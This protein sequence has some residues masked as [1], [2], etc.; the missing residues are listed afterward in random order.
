M[1]HIPTIEIRSDLFFIFT[2]Y[3]GANID[4]VRRIGE[5]FDPLQAPGWVD[6]IVMK[7]VQSI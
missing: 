1:D 2:H 7:V 6:R 4:H 3:N 5:G